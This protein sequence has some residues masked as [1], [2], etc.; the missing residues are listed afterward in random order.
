MRRWGYQ[1]TAHVKPLREF[2]DS[3]G[4]VFDLS[5]NRSTVEFHLISSGCKRI[6]NEL[7]IAQSPSPFYRA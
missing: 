6:F 3:L 5:Q 2:Q 7:K 1:K 4:G